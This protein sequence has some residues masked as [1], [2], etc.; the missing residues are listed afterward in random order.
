MEVVRGPR[1]IRPGAGLPGLER[2]VFVRV[3]AGA[4]PRGVQGHLYDEEYE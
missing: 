1:L 4:V 3:G 2:L